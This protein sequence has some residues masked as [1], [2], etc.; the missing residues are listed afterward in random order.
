MRQSEEIL[1]EILLKIDICKNPKIRYL[2]SFPLLCKTKQNKI[3]NISYLMKHSFL[4]CFSFLFLHLRM[5]RW[6]HFRSIERKMPMG[7]QLKICRRS[8]EMWGLELSRWAGSIGCTVIL[9]AM[10]MNKMAV[11]IRWWRTRGEVKDHPLG[12][13]SPVNKDEEMVNKE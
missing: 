1:E 6:I 2:S 7:Y 9:Q 13:L 4:V 8:P 11:G 12:K 3:P 10:A 5:G